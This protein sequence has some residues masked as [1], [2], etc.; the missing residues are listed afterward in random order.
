[1]VLVVIGATISGCL[2]S[3]SS[4]PEIA[5]YLTGDAAVDNYISPLVDKAIKDGN[6]AALANYKELGANLKKQARELRSQ[7]SVPVTIVID[8]G[9]SG[10]PT[11]WLKPDEVDWDPTHTKLLYDLTK[12]QEA[13][14][15]IVEAVHNSDVEAFDILNGA[16]TKQG[17]VSKFG[18]LNK[19]LERIRAIQPNITKGEPY[20]FEIREDTGD[21][22]KTVASSIGR[23]ATY[24]LHKEL[25][26]V[27][28]A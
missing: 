3:G 28:M 9:F 26:G 27:W 8:E 12:P 1:V 4:T 11:A 5:E 24:N 17:L 16:E 18:S 25:N 10:N 13:T 22:I 6:N 21:K 7:Y 15:A 19:A 2:K 23:E 20:Y 14:L